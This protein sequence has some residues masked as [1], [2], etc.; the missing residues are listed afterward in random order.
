M[1]ATL[2][3]G[4]VNPLTKTRVIDAESCKFTLAVMAT[5]GLYETSGDW[6]Y[7][8]GLPGKSG[9]G[10]GIVTVSPG[11]VDSAHSLRGL[12]TLATAS[13]DSLRRNTFR[14]ALASACLLR[15]RKHEVRGHLSHQAPPIAP[16]RENGPTMTGIQVPGLLTFTI[17]IVV[18]LTGAG[19]NRLIKPLH[20]WNIPEAVTGGVL[21]AR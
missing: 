4:G 2:A 18:F 3:D 13:R 12:T 20:R 6:L 7:E 14:S 21:A 9:I 19:L 15:R 16:S 17:A 8:V 5:A 10:G 11:K 1:G